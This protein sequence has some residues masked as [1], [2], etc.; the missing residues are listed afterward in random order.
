LGLLFGYELNPKLVTS[1]FFTQG[2]NPYISLVH[3][4][5]EEPNYEIFIS[6]SRKDR[7]L[8]RKLKSALNERGGWQIFLDEQAIETGARWDSTL[9]SMLERVLCV[10][11]I[12]TSHSYG[13]EWVRNEASEAMRTGKY[14]PVLL[15]D[16]EQPPVEYRKRQ[17]FKLGLWKGDPETGEFEELFTRLDRFIEKRRPQEVAIK[18]QAWDPLD[19]ILAKTVDREAQLAELE[20]TEDAGKASGPHQCWMF[21]CRTDDWPDA[22]ADHLIIRKFFSLYGDLGF[23]LADSEATRV[24]MVGTNATAFHEALAFQF[25]S[26]LVNSKL[27]LEAWLSN[28][29]QHKVI[30]LS[31]D[32]NKDQN[33]NARLLAIKEFLDRLPPVSGARVTVLVACFLSKFGWFKKWLIAWTT[34]AFS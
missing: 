17:A 28:G 34:T 4:H 24:N 21:H 19:Q 26:L 2:C 32:L 8:V 20:F 6:Y 13:S 27:D 16:I 7:A 15:G 25:P 23:F 31:L 30:Y 12:W 11:V 1:Y 22:L 9:E 29:L 14:F 3:P 10:L 18:D 33:A 5:M